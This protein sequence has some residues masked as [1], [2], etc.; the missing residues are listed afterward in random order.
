MSTDISFYTICALALAFKEKK[1][2]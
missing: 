1:M 2:F